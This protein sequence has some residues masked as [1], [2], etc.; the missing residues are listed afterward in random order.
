MATAEEEYAAIVSSAK[1]PVAGQSLTNDPESPALYERPPEFTSVHAASEY[2]FGK[3][4][5]PDTYVSTMKAINNGVPIM[6]I[7]QSVLFIEFKNGK[8]NP[9]LMLMMV[10][11]TAYMLIALAE[12]LDLNMVIYRGELEDENE[13]EQILGV[14]FAEDRL[15][16]LQKAGQSGRVPQGII[17]LEM[18]KQIEELPEIPELQNNQESLMSR[19]RG[20]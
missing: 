14:S 4:I 1:R 15:K 18:Q 7:V 3:F 13:E 9:D 10:E 2:M 6:D 11:P 5:E 19:P 8:F 12:R 17:N 20:I 16:K